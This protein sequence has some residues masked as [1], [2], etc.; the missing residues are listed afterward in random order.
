M[1][2]ILVAFIGGQKVILLTL[3]LSSIATFMMTKI[4]DPTEFHKKIPKVIVVM[5]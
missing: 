5:N 4:I 1:G 3:V 2:G